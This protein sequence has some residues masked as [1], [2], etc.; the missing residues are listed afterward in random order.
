ML[1]VVLTG[2]PADALGAGGAVS[3]VVDVVVPGTSTP[4]THHGP[5]PPRGPHHLP[6]TGSPLLLLM[7]LALL[8][9]AAGTG[10]RRLTA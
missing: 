4:T 10:L 7:T 3:T 2:A 8:L 6:F 5:A 9:L 1:T